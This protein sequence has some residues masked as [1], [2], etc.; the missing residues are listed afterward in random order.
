MSS[1]VSTSKPRDFSLNVPSKL[2]K[3]SVKIVL[4]DKANEGK[5]KVVDALSIKNPK[6]K[7]FVDICNKLKIKGSALFVNN[8]SN[9]NVIRASRNIPNIKVMHL[10]HLNV[11]DL[12]RHDEVILTKDAVTTLEAKNK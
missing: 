1:L 9:E 11:Y 5:M 6:T 8:E 7:D 12:L 2:K 3:L 4:S 10:N